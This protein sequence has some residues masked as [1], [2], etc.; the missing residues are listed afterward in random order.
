M[1]AATARSM[2]PALV[3]HRAIAPSRRPGQATGFDSPPP[4]PARPASPSPQ[5]TARAKTRPPP[6]CQTPPARSCLGFQA[7]FSAVDRLRPAV[8]PCARR[9]G[10]PSPTH[11]S[12]TNAGTRQLAAARYLL[13]R[14]LQSSIQRSIS[15]S[16][17]RAATHSPQISR[18]ATT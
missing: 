4:Q 6:R 2:D 7:W 3:R 17:V 16:P 15:A 8:A 10:C 12:A 1:P 18:C 9:A 14:F 13:S 5:R 11:P